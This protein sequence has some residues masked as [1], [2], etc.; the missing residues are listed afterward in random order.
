MLKLILFNR[1]LILF[2][3][4]YNWL[5][6]GLYLIFVMILFVINITDLTYFRF[7]RISIGMDF[8]SW[9][10]IILRV[11][12]SILI[13]LR[14]NRI[15]QLKFH[16]SGYLFNVIFLEIILLITFIIINFF[17]FYL[18][19]ERRLIP[20]FLLILGWG[21]QPERI[22]AGIYIL[23]YTLFG[24]LPLLLRIFFLVNEFGR[25]NIVIFEVL[26]QWNF[27]FYI[28][29]ILG[30]LFK[31]PIFIFH[32]W[33]P[34]AH[35]EAPVRGSIILAGVLLKLGGYGLIRVSL[36]FTFGGF[37]G[38]YLI[39]MRLVG[40]V[41]IGIIC[42]Y[43]V[44]VKVI[45]AYSSVVHIGLILGG[46]LTCTIWGMYG[47][48]L[49]MLSHGLCSSGMFYLANVFY[50]RVGRRN[51]LINRGL[52]NIFPF[53][54]FFF[55]IVCAFNGGAPPSLNLWGEIILIIRIVNWSMIYCLA[56]FFVSFIRVCYR[57]FL[58]RR[59]VHGKLYSFLTRFNNCY[60]REYL[61]ICLHV[62]PLWLF[63]LNLNWMVRWI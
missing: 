57:L 33:L 7:I 51:L 28:R 39:I 41:Y 61:V 20:I 5:V 54:R 34:K 22:R 60:V 16:V 46:L 37:L 52:I 26:F 49:I 30:F 31:L 14:R 25:V 58:Y 15:Y 63:F 10:L 2:C 19:F 32:L 44:D 36:I 17:F 35:V 27:F 29:M 21:Y 11:F 4:Y 55:F 23:L 42:I 56:I 53:L 1:M 24:S 38:Y 8:I 6:V 3:W 47:S 13:L 59:V 50:E 43:Q 18:F 45:I 62:L 9:V 48:L 40:G 12:I